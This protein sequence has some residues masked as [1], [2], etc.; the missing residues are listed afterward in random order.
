MPGVLIGLSVED[1]TACKRMFSPD[2]GQ[3]YD[4][5]YHTVL[6]QTQH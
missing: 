5:R 2:M 4:V 3:Y 6:S 1:L